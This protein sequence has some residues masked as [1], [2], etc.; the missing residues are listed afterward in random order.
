MIIMIYRNFNKYEYEW[1]VADGDG[2]GNGF[3]YEDGDGF[4]DGWGAADG[5]GRY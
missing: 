2:F 4:G 3:G 5:D 1:G